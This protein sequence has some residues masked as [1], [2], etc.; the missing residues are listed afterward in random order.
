MRRLIR[1]ALPVGLAAL[2]AFPA[3]ANAQTT[4]QSGMSRIA[5]APGAVTPTGGGVTNSDYAFWGNRL[6]AGNYSGF[7][8]FDISNPAAPVQLAN[9]ICTTSPGTAGQGDISVWNNL[10]FRSVD[11]AQ[12]AP[13]CTRTAAT[14]PGWEGIDIFD[15]SNPAAPRYIGGVATDCGSHTHTLVPD[16]GNNR[17]ILYSSSYPSS[18]LGTSPFPGG[19]QCSRPHNK[20]G[21]VEVP[22]N[23][24][25]NARLL[26]YMPMG[27]PESAIFGGTGLAAGCHDISVFLELDLAA[28]ACLSQGL[29]MDISDPANP[30]ITHR[31]ENA[32]IDVCARRAPVGSDNPLCLWHSATF[33]W[34]GQFMVFGDEA[35]GGGSA[36]CSSEDPESRGSFWMHAVVAPTHPISRFKIPRIQ[37]ATVQ[38]CT[39]HLMNFIPTNV[40][41][42]LPS[43]WY[44]G[45]TS[46]INWSNPFGTPFEFAWYEIEPP[47]ADDPATPIDERANRTNTWATYWYNDYMYGSDN[48]LMPGATGGVD[49]YRLEQPWVGAQ[50]W[51]LDRFNPQTQEE[52]IRCGGPTNVSRLQVGRPAVI[53]DTLLVL[54]DQ[55]VIGARVRLQGAGVNLT[56]RT[57]ASGQTVFRFTP[58]RAGALRIFAP[59]TYNMLGCSARFTVRAAPRRGGGGVRGGGGGGAG[60][61][62]RAAVVQKRAIR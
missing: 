25:Q 5:N 44:S 9:V 3:G 4:I 35:G 54:D 47:A 43:S 52:V 38:N 42:I 59:D 60:L 58:R 18:G 17:V 50:T 57:N 30:T 22:L 29:L 55:P 36:E 32:A 33:T 8:V 37:P 56:R 28:G 34:D 23:A 19:N 14:G 45:G 27:M 21:I 15:I 26:R 20:I 1:L 53:R 46:V 24:P 12:T 48:R 41:Y 51:E 62:G 11:T 49:V 7:R 10:L 13:D 6:Y 16:E 2:V 31:L 40:G 39:A 61:T